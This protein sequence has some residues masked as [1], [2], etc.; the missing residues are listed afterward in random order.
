MEFVKPEIISL[1]SHPILNEKWVQAR[2]GEDPAM[3]GLGDLVL[4]DKE[5]LQPY[6]GRLDLLLQDPE[7]NRRYEVEV[8]LGRTDESHIIRTL[9]YWDIERRRYPQ[10]EHC[11]VLIAEDVTS[12]F[13]N[14]IGLF[15]GFIP[16]IAIQMTAFQ[17]EGKISLMFTKVMDEL[18]L[19]TEEEE[20]EAREATDRAYWERK[21][22][23]LDIIDKLIPMLQALDP[24]LALNYNKFFI[25]LTRSGSACNFV[26][27]YPRKKFLI[28]SFKL[29]KTEEMDARL[30][31]EG[32]DL[33][34]YSTR[35]RAYRVRLTNR[36]VQQ[37]G[38][39]IAELA[40]L[41]Y[42]ARVGE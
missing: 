11:A 17:V 20:E 15:N 33:L 2:I 27:F 12:R 42:E 35:A 26:T 41:A 9:E 28:M 38:E 13:Q 29:P 1:K 25:G 7:D 31:R 21:S 22:P 6:A 10:Y 4:K 37:H 14:V 23:V 8:Q 34:D 19:G 3:L 5:R 30:E 40:K 16:L 24:T 32:L 36:D 39:L 18:T